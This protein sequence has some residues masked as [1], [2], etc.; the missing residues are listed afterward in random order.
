MQVQEPAFVGRALGGAEARHVHAG[1][2]GQ[3]LTVHA[4]FLAAALLCYVGVTSAILVSSDFLPYVT[5]NN[6]SF[7][8]FFHAK[9]ILRF[10]VRASAGLTDEANGDRSAGHPYVYTHAGN[11][12][13]VPVL[14]LLILGINRIEWQITILA[15]LV[16]GLSTYAAFKVFSRMGGDLFAFL[17]IA[18]LSTDYLMYAQWQVNTFRVW[19]AFFLFV[20]LW[21]IQRINEENARAIRALLFLNSVCL[22]YFEFVFGLFVALFSVL[23]AVTL[24]RGHRARITAIAQGLVLGGAVAL[25]LFVVQLV[26]NLGFERASMDFRL[27]YLA[28][29]FGDADSALEGQL[30]RLHFFMKN[31]I[32]YWDSASDAPGFPGLHELVLHL[33]DGVV[34]VYT[35]FLGLVVGI[36]SLFLWVSHPVCRSM[37][38]AFRRGPVGRLV[39]R[40]L[41][42][43]RVPEWRSLLI[44]AVSIHAIWFLIQS[45][46]YSPGRLS[47]WA[48]VIRSQLSE[49][50]LQV[51]LSG[52]LLF[53]VLLLRGGDRVSG[54]AHKCSAGVAGYLLA[55]T[56][57]LVFTNA[58]VPGY[59][60]NGYLSRYA[61]VPVFVTDVWLALVLY[62][63]VAVA[64][65]SAP[66]ALRA[67][68]AARRARSGERARSTHRDHPP[69]AVLFPLS[70][71][72]LLFVVGYWV[73]L[74][75]AYYGKLPPTA[76]LFA[77]QLVRPEFKGASFVTD[78]YS[79]PV[80]YYTDQWAY[81]DQTLH[82]RTP[83]TGEAGTG[84]LISGKYI[85]FADRE[86]N[87]SYLHPQYYLCRINPDLDLAFALSALPANGKLSN[88]SGQQIVR[89][90]PPGQ[91][92]PFRNTLVASDPSP[93]DLWAIVRLDS[94]LRLVPKD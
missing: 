91:P 78:N 47:L 52:S 36:T 34:R 6:E 12:P 27:T 42:P 31:H 82:T 62:A 25:G 79:L 26:V 16:G 56:I 49:L 88:C 40:A 35:P 4:W 28:R 59:M 23:Y 30:R 21:C 67:F 90:A 2:L 63:L 77:R 19:H 44:V 9:N 61:P 92:L 18:V 54:D 38:A 86:A 33:R 17:V 87:D 70:A 41:G 55:G 66:G 32:V 74:Q 50:V 73:M 68:T 71:L 85:W 94:T 13:R 37:G 14:A 10:G 43:G 64:R 72:L 65:Q 5:D 53:G 24:Y 11:F 83:V 45:G 57:A 7:S 89:P 8:S 39:D 84:V 60:W 58:A 20:S 46:L 3:K 76:I 29:S 81:Q 1:W 80:A 15:F 48:G 75:A 93:G 22:F 51:V 69:S